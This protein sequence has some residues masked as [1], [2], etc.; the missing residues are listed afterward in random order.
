MK[1]IPLPNYVL[2]EL[3][4]EKT[5]EHDIHETGFFYKKEEPLIYRV[6]DISQLTNIN[7]SVN[8]KILISS[9]PTKVHINDKDYYLV[10]QEHIAGF[11]ID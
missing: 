5:H 10:N 9:T 6:I 1:V 7:V 11:V 8:D 2:C 4:N 3:I